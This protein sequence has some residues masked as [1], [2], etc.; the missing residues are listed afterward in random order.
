M[1][2]KHRD[3]TSRKKSSKTSSEEAEA[4]AYSDLRRR[5]RRLSVDLWIWEVC[6]LLLSAFC[7]GAII[8]ILI[9]YDNKPIPDWD[10]GLTINGIISVLAVVAKA[11][12]ILPITKAISQLKWNWFWKKH[13]PVQDF[14]FI[15]A[16]SRGP[17]SKLFTM[18]T[19]RN[20][21]DLT[22]LS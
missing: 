19:N 8:V 16:A 4:K 1:V 17:V 9:E 12:M 2:E 10:L 3:E 6:S 22:S 15:D 7:V 5:L 14:Q 20:I 11:S 13:R 21:A 18:M